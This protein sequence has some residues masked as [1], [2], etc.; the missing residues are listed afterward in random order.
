MTPDLSMYRLVVLQGGTQ[1]YRTVIR[2]NSAFI[3]RDPQCRVC[4]DDRALA[5]Q[6][7]VLLRIN[8]QVRVR[9]LENVPP[10]TLRGEPVS[11]AVLE[12]GDVLDIGGFHVQFQVIQPLDPCMTRRSGPIFM[13]AMFGLGA[14]GVLQLMIIGWFWFA[15]PDRVLESDNRADP[16]IIQNTVEEEKI[17]ALGMELAEARSRLETLEI[18]HGNQSAED[19]WAGDDS[20][21]LTE[22]IDTLRS[23]VRRL[24]DSV[25]YFEHSRDP[26]ARPLSASDLEQ[27]EQTGRQMLT[28]ARRSILMNDLDGADRQL[29]ELL[30]LTPDN[31]VAYITYARLKER[32]G[33]LQSAIEHWDQVIQR[34]GGTPKHEEATA[35]RVRLIREIRQRE[36]RE[37]T[38]RDHQ[39]GGATNQDQAQPERIE[40]EQPVPQPSSG[41]RVA[42]RGPPIA[43]NRARRSPTDPRALAPQLNM[44]KGSGLPKRLQIKSVRREKFQNRDNYEE[45][46]LLRIQL[47][48]RKSAGEITADG[49][50]IEVA[51]Y[52]RDVETGEIYVSNV[53]APR[54]GL[55]LKETWDS[56]ETKSFSALY[57]VPNAYRRDERERTHRSLQFYGYIVRVYDETI[58]Q[59]INSFPATLLQRFP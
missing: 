25:R 42:E 30:K 17:D 3:G 16:P 43:E 53:P 40:T 23:R 27:I 45:I 15:G 46:R 18:E 33:D 10:V 55:E 20:V 11:D 49:L 8:G 54:K 4:L 41:Q 35:E 34:V 6:H 56:G 29:T 39:P 47:K 9:V 2:E 21:R 31:V 59:D 51:F 1:T 44:K 57:M 22:E 50:R 28:Q 58:L 5:P 36:A 19:I 48:R 24:E 7:V 26:A 37:R 13:L 38:V 52:D 12:H 32:L 14:V